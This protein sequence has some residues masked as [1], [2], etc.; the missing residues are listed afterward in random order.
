MKLLKTLLIFIFSISSVAQDCLFNNDYV[1]VGNQ[2]VFPSKHLEREGCFAWV[3]VS[4]RDENFQ[5]HTCKTALP[6]AAGI[7]HPPNTVY[8]VEDVIIPRET[9]NRLFQQSIPAHYV[10]GLYYINSVETVDIHYS[11][12]K[13]VTHVS[14]K[15]VSNCQGMFSIISR[16][17][18]C[19]PLAFY[20]N[21]RN[22][23][24]HYELISDDGTEEPY[25]LIGTLSSYYLDTFLFIPCLFQNAS[26]KCLE[27]DY[28]NRRCKTCVPPFEGYLCEKKK[29]EGTCKSSCLYG[30]CSNEGKCECMIGYTGAACETY[31]AVANLQL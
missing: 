5:P 23:A 1:Q 22:P 16:K 7:S 18:K 11:G 21:T 8:N 20:R 14:M 25:V 13:S 6:E 24:I 15:N 9:L 26:V 2:L 19:F 27:W 3:Q 10:T 28:A 31:S 30:V 17:N 12:R 29:G 4:R